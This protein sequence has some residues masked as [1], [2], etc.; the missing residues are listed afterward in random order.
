MEQYAAASGLSLLGCAVE[1]LICTC[2]DLLRRRT[3]CRAEHLPVPF[4]GRRAGP[5]SGTGV[6]HA[7][8]D[9][10][11]VEELVAGDC[12]GGDGADPPRS[13]EL[14]GRRTFRNGTR[15][16]DL[17]CGVRRADQHGSPRFQAGEKLGLGVYVSRD[18]RRLSDRRQH[19][20]VDARNIAQL[21][22]PF[23]RIVV[24]EHRTHCF[25]VIC[26]EIA[27]HPVADVVLCEIYPL[28]LLQHFWLIFTQPEHLRQRPR[29]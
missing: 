16:V 24:A 7:G 1:H 5:C 3:F 6:P 17:H 20:H 10:L 23:L 21:P 18:I 13:C 27:G 15:G 26:A 28:G 2:S 25:N 12:S 22:A 9:M 8:Y 14:Y 19:G 29:R 4:V 11:V